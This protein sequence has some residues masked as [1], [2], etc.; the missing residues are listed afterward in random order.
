MG[1]GN[2]TAFTQIV[3]DRLGVP[4][5]RV[6]VLSGDTDALGAGRGNGGSGALTVGGSALLR[7]T[8]K[9]IERGRRLAAQLLRAA[10]EDLAL[11]DGKFA[12]AGTDRGGPVAQVG[13][14]G[15]VARRPPAR[16]G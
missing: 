5:S 9:V 8:D 14:A 10:P 3:A 13:R 16:T 6:Q 7:P 11:P 12:L 2:D 4:P 15:D 1:Q